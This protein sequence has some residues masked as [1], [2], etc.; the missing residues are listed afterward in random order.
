[1]FYTEKKCYLERL[2]KE[3]REIF[4]QPKESK[5]RMSVKETH[6]RGVYEELMEMCH[7]P[8]T[9]LLQHF[10]NLSKRRESVQLHMPQPLAPH[11]AQFVALCWTD[12][13][14]QP[15]PRADFL[16]PIKSHWSHPRLKT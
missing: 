11:A 12:R 6:L 1:M 4:Q 9:E 2:E 8:D 14:A 10:E 5:D 16:R 15:T 7:K 3:S 13:Q